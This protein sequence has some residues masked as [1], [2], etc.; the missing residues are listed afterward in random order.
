MYK[1]TIPDSVPKTS[2]NVAGSKVNRICDAF[3]KSL[4]TRTSTNLQNLISAHV[5]KNPPALEEGLLEIANLRSKL[6]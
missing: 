2:E 6:I 4:E 3:L 1:E 5:C